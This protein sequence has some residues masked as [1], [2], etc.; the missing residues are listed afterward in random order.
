MGEAQGW[1]AVQQRKVRVAYIIVTHSQVVPLPERQRV[2]LVYRTWLLRV[3][4]NAPLFELLVSKSSG[5]KESA[6]PASLDSIG[7]SMRWGRYSECVL[8][9]VQQVGFPLL[10][11]KDIFR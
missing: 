3:D 9:D 2:G 4:W 1:R 11:W 8:L 5:A 7:R 6:A 10:Q